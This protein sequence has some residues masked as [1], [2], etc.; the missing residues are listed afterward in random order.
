MKEYR[1][2]SGRLSID[3]GND[4]LQFMVF[5]SR[6][7]RRCKARLIQKLNELDQR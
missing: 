6:L 4:D 7:E 5:V 3:L 1:D 2:A